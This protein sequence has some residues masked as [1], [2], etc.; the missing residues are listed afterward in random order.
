LKTVI[1]SAITYNW[2][3]T[4]PFIGL[5]LKFKSINQEY[6]TETELQILRQRKFEIERLSHIKDIFL[7][8]CFTGLAYSDIL[9][10]KRSNIIKGIDNTNW[11]SIARTKTNTQCK[12]P[13]LPDAER[14]I[15][16]YQSHPICQ[17]TGALLPVCS[18]QK[19][20][21]YLKEIGV[22]CGLRKNLTTHVAR[23][24]FATIASENNVPPETIVKIIG[25]SSFKHLHLYLKTSDQKIAD[26][27]KE[28]RAKYK[29]I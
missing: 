18:N 25:H 29:T 17:K 8:G 4:D 28:F 7:F 12:I 2:I 24:T 19:M 26:D 23:R 13:L 5:K 9:K 27:L 20:N 3:E 6:L 10:A 11:L 21:A 16:K 15:E 14:L 1:S 22:L